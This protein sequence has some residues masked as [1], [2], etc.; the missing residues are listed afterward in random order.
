[1]KIGQKVFV[2]KVYHTNSGTDITRYSI[3]TVE[4]IEGG[5]EFVFINGIT[6]PF[7]NGHAQ[8]RRQ[9][10]ATIEP[11][12]KRHLEFYL[13]KINREFDMKKMQDELFPNDSLFQK[14]KS[15]FK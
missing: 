2:K 10:T 4:R 11:L 15:Y 1:M 12:T 3:K 6:W 5:G 7:K 9:I 13:Q 14:I 8:T